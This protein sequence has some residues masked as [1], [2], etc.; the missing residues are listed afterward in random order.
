MAWDGTTC[1]GTALALTWAQATEVVGSFPPSHVSGSKPWRLPN[2]A[3]LYSLAERAC[4]TPAINSRWFPATPPDGVWS[5]SLNAGYNE[6]AWNVD[7][8]GG[9]AYD[10][11]KN[12]AYRVRLVRSGD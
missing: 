10:G 2:H 4:R 6:L 3:E 9:F 12:Q 8:D 7:F 5:S 11:Y 1:S